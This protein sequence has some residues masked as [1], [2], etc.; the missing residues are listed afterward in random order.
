MD[1]IPCVCG[2]GEAIAY[3]FDI[4]G[5]G[6][7]KRFKCPACGVVMYSTVKG[8][9]LHPRELSKYLERQGSK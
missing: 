9:R 8:E 4:K 1:S 5:K 3:E 2:K 6:H 7:Y